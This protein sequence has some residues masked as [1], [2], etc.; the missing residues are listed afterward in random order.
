M[1]PYIKGGIV[2]LLCIAA[3]V[4]FSGASGAS[5]A[6]A[7]TATTATTRSG[8]PEGFQTATPAV[9]KT[10][11]NCQR[12]PTTDSNVQW[13]CNTQ[14]DATKLINNATEVDRTFL[15]A[16]DQVCF[17]YGDVATRKD[18]GKLQLTYMCYDKHKA[19]FT[20]ADYDTDPYPFVVLDTYDSLCSN[21]RAS[22]TD[23]GGAVDVTNAMEKLVDK[24]KSDINEQL[25]RLKSL[26]T[27]MKCQGL[28]SPANVVAMC[29]A[30]RDGITKIDTELGT[31]DKYK[32]M[33]KGPLDD[34]RGSRASVKDYADKFKCKI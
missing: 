2:I 12:K 24:S 19:S 1:K 5:G 22:D 8:A 16:G 13:L 27:N 25:Q 26:Y 33:I 32:S 7:T 15:E 31:I 29:A 11:P 21:I 28:T 18:E 6:L 10:F 30:I 17:T 4:I 34:L 23:L 14:K 3:L 9:E 20:K